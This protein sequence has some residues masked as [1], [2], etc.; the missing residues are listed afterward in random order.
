MLHHICTQTFQRV[1]FQ[2]RIGTVVTSCQCLCWLKLYFHQKI[3]FLLAFSLV[4]LLNFEKITQHYIFLGVG[5]IW[6]SKESD[7][8]EQLNNNKT[9]YIFQVSVGLQD[10]SGGSCGKDTACHVGK[11]DSIP[12]SRRY[13]GEGNYNPLQ[14]S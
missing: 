5:F 8:T 11:P 12:G 6:G 14:Y 1:L 3:S 7:M 4:L 2:A 10:C 13:P 9:I